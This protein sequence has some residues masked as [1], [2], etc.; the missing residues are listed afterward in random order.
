MRL[1]ETKRNLAGGGGGNQYFKLGEGQSVMIRFLY[2]TV[3][4]IIAEGMMAHVIPPSECGQQFGITV[5]CGSKT[6]E[7]AKE[8][9]KWCAKDYKPYG[10]YPLA[11]YNEDQQSIQYWLR[12]S[13]YVDGL[14]AQLSEIVSQG[15]PISGQVF[16]MI[17]TGKGTQAQYT[18]IQQGS[19]DGKEPSQFGEIK[20]PE[21]RG[22]M[23]P[24]DYE[25][26]VV[27]NNGANFQNNGYNNGNNYQNNNYQNNN[28]NNYQGNYNAGTPRRT[29]DVF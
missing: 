29:T 1:T 8:D 14:V 28:Y 21:E 6:D 9:C 18:I 23:K 11:L 13:Q 10:R 12:S 5:M 16:K 3:D 2:N 25:L 27:S 15:Q 4:D 19:N 17:R 20:I 24:A 26:P 22:T 7:T